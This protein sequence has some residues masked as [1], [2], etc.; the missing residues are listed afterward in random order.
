MKLPKPAELKNSD[1]KYLYLHDT[2]EFFGRKSW[3]RYV[4]MNRFCAVIDFIRRMIVRNSAVIDV[5]CAQG[6]FSLALA[7]FGYKIYGVDLRSSFIAYAKLKMSRNEKNITYVEW[8]VVDAKN[9]PFQS[10]SV[11]CVLLLE[12]LEHT[13]LPE[14]MIE[15]ACRILKKGGYLIVSTVNQKRIRMTARSISYSEFKKSE[16]K[17]ISRTLPDSTAKGS[18]HI[19]EFQMME[20][21][22]LLRKFKLKIVDAK[23]TTFLGFRFLLAKL[24][25]YNILSIL[26]RNFLKTY[27]MKEKF[28]MGFTFFCL[29]H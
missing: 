22:T 28:A 14:K 4:Y 2:K 9:L 13:A 16:S 23:W 21:L 27:R 5:G 29:K 6:N 1:A 17:K 3:E 19:F 24:F 10:D 12:V 8:T 18:E 26:E 15:E 11:D 25:D 7:K 20:L